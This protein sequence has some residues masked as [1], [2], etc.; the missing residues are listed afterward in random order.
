MGDVIHFGDRKSKNVNSKPPQA[1]TGTV[2]KFDTQKPDP[3]KPRR[4]VSEKTQDNFKNE[5]RQ[6][7]WVKFNPRNFF[8]IFDISKM[9]GAQNDDIPFDDDPTPR[10]A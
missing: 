9:P 8:G 1:V 5:V 10:A 3:K 7:Q 2:I 4:I 6:Y